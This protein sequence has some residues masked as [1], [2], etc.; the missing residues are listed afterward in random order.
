MIKAYVTYVVGDTV[1]HD[2][3]TGERMSTQV[4]DQGRALVLFPEEDGTVANNPTADPQ[5]TQVRALHYGQVGR[6]VKM[7]DPV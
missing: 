2:H 1:C 3:L 4:W 7:K 6:I 5:F